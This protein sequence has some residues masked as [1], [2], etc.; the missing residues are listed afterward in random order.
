[1][2]KELLQGV[3]Q[4]DEGQPSKAGSGQQE[5]R[6]VRTQGNPEGSLGNLV[7]PR[8]GAGCLDDGVS[9]SDAGE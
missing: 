6:G 2:L 8:N 4:Q 5:Q 3:F 1:M 9:V 7:V